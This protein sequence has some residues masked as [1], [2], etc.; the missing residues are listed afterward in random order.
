MR[1][2][3]RHAHHDR[4]AAA[5]AAG[6]GRSGR[7]SAPRRGSRRAGRRASGTTRRSACEKLAPWHDAQLAWASSLATLPAAARPACGRRCRRRPCRAA[8]SRR[9]RR[10]CPAR[11]AGGDRAHRRVLALALLV[12]GE[13]GDDVLR[14]LA[15]D[16]RHLVD[17]GEARLVARDVVA[18]DAHRRP[19]P[20][21]RRRCRA[22][23]PGRVR[24]RR[25]RGRGR[26]ERSRTTRSSWVFMGRGDEE[27]GAR[28]NREL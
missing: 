23:R 20:R 22:S 10:P 1:E 25:A 9:R 21:P 6:C 4:V 15:R 16:L 17:L 12:A 5:D 13:R 14:V 18:A 27:I 7:P 19:W 3:P 8:R 28:A 24:R 11:T 26:G 2:R